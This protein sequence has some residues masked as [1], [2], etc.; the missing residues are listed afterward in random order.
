M[1]DRGGPERLGYPV[2]EVYARER[3]GI[4]LRQLRE[5]A[6][7]GRAL[8]ELPEIE[9]ALLSGALVWAKVVL[10]CRV[11]S[12]D[13]ELQWIALA[14]S[15][16][17]AALAR[18]VRSVDRRASRLEAAAEGAPAGEGDASTSRDS[19]PRRSL[20]LAVTA[21]L[22]A[23]W[24]ATRQLA[25]RVEGRRLSPA[26]FAEILIAEVISAM[27]S[28]AGE[29]READVEHE[30]RRARSPV[31]DAALPNEPLRAV[32]SV[33]PEIAAWS[34]GIDQLDAFA[35]DARLRQAVRLEARS[36]ARLAALLLELA[37]TRAWRDLGF[38]GF[39]TYAAERAGLSPSRASVLLRIARAAACA[40][41]LR[42]VWEAG[43][44]PSTKAAL[45]ASLVSKGA[46][47]SL[48][49]WIERARRVTTRRLEQ[50]V[51]QALAD[52][53]LD[54]DAL[55]AL[56]PGLPTCAE[57]MNSGEPTKLPRPDGQLVFAVPRTVAAL[58]R[59]AQ[60]A[61]QR[62]IE[63]A[64]GRTANEAEAL[65][66]MLDHALVTWDAPDRADRRYRVFERDG[67]RCTAPGCTSFRNLHA[68][69]V[70]F[71]SRGGDD[72]PSNLVTLC[73]AHHQHAVH[74]NRMRVVGTAP[75]ALV[76]ELGLRDEKAPLER[77]ASGDRA[78]S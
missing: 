74:A 62:R 14:R 29:T 54:P 60:A 75:D 6:R 66:A 52:P 65:D 16:P 50:D 32:P 43:E 18:E 61:I 57:A 17:V 24:Y 33:S 3:L 69:H 78:M 20:R 45:L 22:R 7:V 30:R 51:E 73:A 36:D 48:E 28:A 47:S 44:L 9:R 40:P 31:R 56:P 35:L 19:E 63:H 41:E 8:P 67:W 11:A 49:G 13:D 34:Q 42:R 5:L 10:L 68:H 12:Q 39:A 1:L 59:A 38:Q 21:P 37:G 26:D 2:L 58:F 77:F 25:Q 70:V 72:R 55:P 76:Y 23:K 64:E 46:G 71:R 53:R 4:S 15:L 27:P